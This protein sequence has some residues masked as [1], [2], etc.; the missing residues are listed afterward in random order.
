[1]SVNPHNT[2]DKRDN[3]TKKEGSRTSNVSAYPDFNFRESLR[4]KLKDSLC[5]MEGQRR[6]FR[7]F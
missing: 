5:T 1:M 7:E 2:P 6:I 3:I 4:Q